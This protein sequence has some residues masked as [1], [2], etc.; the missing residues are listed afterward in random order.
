[1]GNRLCHSHVPEPLPLY[2][3]STT[4]LEL[5]HR[6]ESFD[7]EACL[8]GASRRVDRAFPIIDQSGGKHLA[9]PQFAPGTTAALAGTAKTGQG[10]T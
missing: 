9:P 2:L 10:A 3:K 7:G 6:C 8:E 1:M 4:K 5:L